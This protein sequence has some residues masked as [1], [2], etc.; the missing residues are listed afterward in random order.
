MIFWFALVLMTAAAIGAVLWPLSRAGSGRGGSDTE[1]YL[2]QLDEIKRDRS[3]GLI[4][5][6]EAEAARVEVSR[7][8]IAAADAAAPAGNPSIDGA[9]IGR[10]RWTAIAGIALLPVGAVSLYLAL[11]SPQMS[12]GPP[13]AAASAEDRSI[14]ALV[15]R[16]EAHIERNP[17]DGRAWEVLAPVYMR[18]GRLDDAVTAWRN[19]IRL[20]GVSASRVADYGEAMVAAANGVVTAEAKAAFDQAFALDKQDVMARFYL[21]MAA[22]QDGRRAEADAIWQDLLASAPPGAPWVEVV[23]HAMARTAP[24][25]P[26]AAPA[27]AA[28][29]PSVADMKAAANLAPD[30]QDQMVA[31]MVA[32]L[33]ERLKQNG[34]DVE[35]WLRLVRSYR[36]LGQNDKLQAAIADA[37]RA[38]AGEP[39][40]LA[41]FT[42]RVES[43]EASPAVAAAPAATSAPAVPGPNVAE[44]KAAANLAPDQQDQVVAGMVARLAERLKQNGSDVEGWLRLVRSYRV[45]GQN[46]K[47]Q[48]AIADAG[49]A[50]AGEPDKLAEFTKRV[51]SGEAA[52]AL[53]P[54]AVATAPGPGAADVSAAAGMSDKDRNAMIGAMVARLADRLKENGN[55]LD[56]WQRLLRAYIVLGERDKAKAAAADAR[57]V[58][59]SDPDKLRHIDDTIKSLGL[60]G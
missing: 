2:D 7:R 20:N 53:P 51:E 25:A 18:L 49:R 32:R 38:L 39:D 12:G 60:E 50:L 54:A 26:A 44:M 52:P 33:A 24:A 27:P 31:G 41:E 10:R 17:E 56:G 11:G 3:A 35:G 14:E 8:L 6:S 47:L 58:L 57:R 1:V 46:D 21:G 59:S 5:E 48:A 28:P 15:A 40:K 43:G 34:S 9:Q 45:L 16:V 13:A 22:D 36:V 37:R 42:K 23:R 19:V 30:Q 4:G 55:D 29:G